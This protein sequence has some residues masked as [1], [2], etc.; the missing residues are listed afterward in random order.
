MLVTEVIMRTGLRITKVISLS[1]VRLSRT[2][3]LEEG[4]S[5][6]QEVG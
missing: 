5:L 6:E 2:K 1:T 3:E 4:R